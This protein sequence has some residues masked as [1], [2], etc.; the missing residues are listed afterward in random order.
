MNKLSILLIGV[1][2]L[3]SLIII[4]IAVGFFQ[5]VNNGLLEN[6]K[7][8]ETRTSTGYIHVNCSNGSNYFSKDN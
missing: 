7:C 3:N 6:V 2:V 8:S 1:C 5:S 4:A